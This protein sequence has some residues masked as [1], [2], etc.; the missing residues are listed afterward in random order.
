MAGQSCNMKE[1]FELSQQYG[2]N[3]IEDASHALGGRYQKR[4]VGGCNYSD[5]VVFSFHPVKIITTAEA[6]LL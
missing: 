5:I 1:I 6:A 4:P 2:F 3:I